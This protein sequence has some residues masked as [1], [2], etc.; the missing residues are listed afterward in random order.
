MTKRIASIL[1][2]TMACLALAAPSSAGAD[3]SLG[4]GREPTTSLALP[5]F[6]LV[7]G[8][9]LALATVAGGIWWADR[10]AALAPC[11]ARCVNEASLQRQVRTMAGMTVGFGVA[12][13]AVTT[14]GALLLRQRKRANDP[15]SWWG[16]SSPEGVELGLI[17]RF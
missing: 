3:E 17:G 6:L 11:D 10:S 12:S 9:V 15:V 1:L 2:A 13:I 4:K 16:R 7:S 8:G 5:R 14:V